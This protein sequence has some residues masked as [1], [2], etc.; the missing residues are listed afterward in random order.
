MGATPFTAFTIPAS[1][2]ARASSGGQFTAYGPYVWSV[3]YGDLKNK[4]GLFGSGGGG[5]DFTVTTIGATMK[6]VAGPNQFGGVMQLLGTYY[7]N[8]GY[9]FAGH[10]SAASY[11]WLFQSHGGPAPGLGG[12][13]PAT[14]TDTNSIITDDNGATDMSMVKVFF[15]PWTTGKVSVTAFDGPNE[16]HHSREGFDNRSS[17]G[18]GTIQLV[19]PMLASWVWQQGAYE[20]GSIGILTVTVPEPQEWMMLGAGFSL[21]G[22]LYGV[23]RRRR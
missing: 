4:Q 3:L 20:T 13:T 16:T 10:N 12:G 7:G 19:T 8:E 5:G 15:V 6:G 1:D 11:T 22:L 9:D 2:L 17:M 18:A 23:N 14:A 21:L